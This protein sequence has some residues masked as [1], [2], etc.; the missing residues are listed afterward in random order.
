MSLVDHVTELRGRL[1]ISVIVFLLAFSVSYL[2]SAEIL[3]FLWDHFL[4]QFSMEDGQVSL[5]A[6]SMMSGFVTQLNISLILAAAASIPVF[7]YEMFLFIE[8]ALN[9]KHRLIAA[10]IIISASLLFVAGTAFV[11]YIMLPMLISFFIQSNSSLG[12]SN[13][14]SV[15]SFFEFIMLNMFLGGIIFQMPL[16][17]TMA[18]RIGIL[19]REWLL[20]SRRFV[21]IFI[22]L[23][24]GIITPDHSIISQ[25][26]LSFAMV[27]LFEISLLFSK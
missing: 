1:R 18:N 13:Y 12:I 4:G 21:Y 27:L 25:L 26:V 15:E 24:A 6:T 3:L 19:P 20:R 11:Y 22:L 2:F 7:I 17:L 23:M 5:L 8:P 16:L 10:K 9:K 14:F